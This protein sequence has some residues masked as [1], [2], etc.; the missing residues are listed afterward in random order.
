MADAEIDRLFRLM[1]AAG[2]SDLH[3]SVG[4]PPMIRKDGQIAP[5]EAEAP[6]LDPAA[7]I[8]L[9]D[10]IMPQKNRDEFAAS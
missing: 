3:L 6:A 10:P 5:L 9:L 2:A 1:T 8:A 7:M 4:M